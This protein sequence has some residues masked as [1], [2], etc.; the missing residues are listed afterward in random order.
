[1]AAWYGS[2]AATG[3]RQAIVSLMHPH[4]VF[5]ESRLGGGAVMKRRPPAL[6]NIGIDLSRRSIDTF[7]CGCPA[8]P[9]AAIATATAPGG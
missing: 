8:I 5:L 7:R 2:K 6:R 9:A 1:M 4:G 3:L